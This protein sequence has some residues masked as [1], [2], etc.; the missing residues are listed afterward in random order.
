L[1]ENEGGTL[2][3]A[4]RSCME[5]WA[6]LAER[7]RAG[8]EVGTFVGGGGAVD[9]DCPFPGQVETSRACA[10]VFETY[11]RAGLVAAASA[12]HEEDDGQ[13][14]EGKAGAAALDERLSLAARVGRAAPEESLALLCAAMEGKKNA[15]AQALATQ[16]VDPS[17]TLEELWWLA[18]LTPHVLCDPF[19]GEFPLPPE[20]IAEWYA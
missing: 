8:Q 3:E 12:A 15:L 18:R 17:E 20:S 7:S 9:T 5:A 4:L 16:N 14:E 6:N 10:A 13:E 2:D 19:E 1:L 11:L